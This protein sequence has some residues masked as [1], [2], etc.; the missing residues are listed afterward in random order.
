MARP[1]PRRPAFAVIGGSLLVAALTFPMILIMCGYDETARR[2][3]LERV[4]IG[5]AIV[6]ASLV[7]LAARILVPRPRRFLAR[8]EAAWTHTTSGGYGG[9][10]VT[11]S[12]TLLTEDGVTRTYGADGGL[13]VQDSD[14]VGV[15]LVAGGRLVAF[16]R[17][18]V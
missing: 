7:V 14:D 13:S 9:G 16:D 10:L 12:V 6:V 5:E 15:A 8:V 3:V 11:R 2:F 4:V 18:D 1:A 17:L